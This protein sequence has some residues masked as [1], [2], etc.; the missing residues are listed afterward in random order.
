MRF[1]EILKTNSK[2]AKS[3]VKSQ[4]DLRIVDSPKK[5]TNKFVGVFLLLS[6]VGRIYGAQICLW[7]YLTFTHFEKYIPFRFS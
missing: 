5:G 4:A 1:D 2:K 3:R 6:F 7:F